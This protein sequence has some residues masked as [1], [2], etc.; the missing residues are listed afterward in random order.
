MA[1]AV[2]RSDAKILLVATGAVLL[3]GCL[4][5]AVLLFATGRDAGPS[6]YAPFPAGSASAIKQQLEDGGPF[7]FP[8]PFGGNRNILLGLEGGKVV[9]LSDLVPNT[10]SCRIRWKGRINSFVDCHGDKLKSTEMDRF[11]SEIGETGSTKGLLLIDLRHKEPAPRAPDSGPRAMGSS[12]AAPT[13][14]A[15]ASLPLHGSARRLRSCR[16][17]R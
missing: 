15:G 11:E 2:S 4:V 9:A 3:A 13:P 1:V 6:K 10:T 8:D 17:R 7:F 14:G 5:A 16:R 12:A